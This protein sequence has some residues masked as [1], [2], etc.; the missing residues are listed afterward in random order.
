MAMEFAS[1]KSMKRRGIFFFFFLF[2]FYIFIYLFGCDYKAKLLLCRYSD[3]RAYGQ[4]KLANILHIKELTRRFQV[5]F[6]Y[7]IS[8]SKFI[9]DNCFC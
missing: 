5:I 6:L 1:T 2:K 8:L 7:S 9:L 4:S 3:K